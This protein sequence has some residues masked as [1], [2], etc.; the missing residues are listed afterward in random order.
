MSR[1]TDAIRAANAAGRPALAAFLT[2]GFPH[3]ETFPDLLRAV[4]GEADLIEIGV[5]FSDPMAD[6]LTIQRSIRAALASGVTLD[7]I[8]EGLPSAG[9]LRTPLLLMSYLNPILALG[10]KS[11]LA[12]AARSGVSGLIVPDLPFEECAPVREAC[13][14]T[15]LDLVQ[16]VTP[17]TPPERL[18]RLC[19]ASRGFVYA[20]TMTGTTGG[21]I[22]GRNGGPG[23]VSEGTLVYLDRV[24]E[25]SPVPVLAGFGVRE[26]RD[27]RAIAARAHGAIVGSA[28]VEVIERG[29]DPVSF[30]QELKG[31]VR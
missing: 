5:P 8:L 19:R 23:G 29:A 6:G 11:V 26:P 7:G 4:A 12:R 28:L 9:A 25:V 14:E 13:D 20:V 2:A 16:L 17:V 3:P 18:G 24:R 15:G 21:S 27:V 30:L 1:I 22:G 31:G 10:V